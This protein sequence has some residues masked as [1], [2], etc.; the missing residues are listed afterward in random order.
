ICQ[1]HHGV[2]DFK[3]ADSFSISGTPVSGSFPLHPIDVPDIC[4]G[5]HGVGDF[6]SADSFSISGTP[7]SGSFPLHPI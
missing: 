1:G 5:H 2:G 7:V 6:K 4:Q 3:S